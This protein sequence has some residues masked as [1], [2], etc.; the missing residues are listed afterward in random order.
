MCVRLILG[1]MLLVAAGCGTL[2]NPEAEKA[3]IESA[4]G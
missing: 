4:G 3:A 2:G 1:T